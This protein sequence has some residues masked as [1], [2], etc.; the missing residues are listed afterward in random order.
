[1]SAR[2]WSESIQHWNVKQ[3]VR[4]LVPRAALN[5]REARYFGKYGEVEMHLV[6]FLC[7]L[8]REAIDVGANF[9]GYVHFMRQHARRVV[10]FEP[11]PEFVELL[12]RKFPRDVT[13]EPIALSDRETEAELYIPLIDDVMV[14]GCSTISAVASLAYP[15]HRLLKVRTNRLD[16]VYGGMAGFIKIDVEGHE[17]AVLEG[18][19]ETI[20][21]CRPRM[22]VEVDENLSPGGLER[23]GAYFAR[24]GYRGHYVHRGRFEPLEKFSVA[25][26]QNPANQPDLRAS[27]RERPRYDDYVNNFIFLPSDEPQETLEAIRYRLAT[28]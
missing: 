15:A 11:I 19:V 9:G 10:A 2:P 20:D 12:R 23:A 17:Q 21:R 13:I 27:L 8:D 28:L 24:L 25:N 16:N 26:L 5:W 6:K 7:R 4:S 3:T 18:A 22:L 14:S 1:M